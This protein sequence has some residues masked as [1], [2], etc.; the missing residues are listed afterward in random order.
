MPAFEVFQQRLLRLLG[1]AVLALFAELLLKA[2]LFL[3]ELLLPIANLAY[4]FVERS[5][6]RQHGIDGRLPTEHFGLSG[7][8]VGV[9]LSQTLSRRGCGGIRRVTL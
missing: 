8:N 9:A 1:T 4:S 6:F 2:F 5:D 7:E 3:A